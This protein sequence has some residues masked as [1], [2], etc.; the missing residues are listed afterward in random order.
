[1]RPAPSPL[2]P[3]SLGPVLPLDE[4]DDVDTPLLLDVVLPPVVVVADVPPV[5]PPVVALPLEVPLPE[6]V[7]PEVLSEPLLLPLLVVP[8]VPHPEEAPELPHA[9]L[10]TASATETIER[11]PRYLPRTRAWLAM[12]RR[13]PI[14]APAFAP[15]KAKSDLRW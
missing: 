9:M 2:E 14:L 10:A 3:A 5:V 11:E 12:A 15:R 4:P 1:M 13:S 8:V 7:P 6:V